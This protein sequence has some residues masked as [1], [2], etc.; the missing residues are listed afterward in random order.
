MGDHVRLGCE[1]EVGGTEAG[2]GCACAGLRDVRY[3][4]EIVGVG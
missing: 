4:L 1:T 2:G 3:M